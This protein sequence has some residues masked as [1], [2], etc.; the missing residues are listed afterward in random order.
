M[1]T[2]FL[3]PGANGVHNATDEAI[4]QLY[5]WFSPP[6]P[7][8]AS[9]PEAA[10]SLTLKGT[11]DG[12]EALMTVRGQSA[13]E[14]QANLQAIRGLLDAPQPAP[15]ARVSSQDK[16]WCAKHAVQRRQTTKQ[17]RSWYS[18]RL[19]DGTWCKGK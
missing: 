7:T 6:P 15:A 16:G 18:H 10:F 17:G 8:P 11:L 13:A 4:D 3:P 5:S 19:A 9:C 14:F 12:V 2:T 1:S